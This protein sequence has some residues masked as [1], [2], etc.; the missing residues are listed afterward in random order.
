MI[1]IKQGIRQGAKLSTTMY[2][3]FN[4]NILYA[5]EDARIG[6]YI[7]SENVTSPTCAD[8]LALVHKETNALQTLTNIV[9]YHAC[10]DRFKINPTKSE[11]VHIYPQKKDS[12][13]EQE[14]KL[15]ESIIQQVE[16]SKH[17]GIERNSNNTP[18]IQER[19]RTARKTMYALMGAGMHGTDG[20]SPIITFNMWTTYVIPRMLHGIEMLTIRKGDINSLEMFQRKTFKQLQGLPKNAPTAAVYLLIGAIPA[21]G[22]IHLRF[23]STFGNI[24][25]NKDSLEYRVAKR[26]LV[27]KDGNSNSWFT[28]LV[29]IHEKYELPSPITLLENP[30]N[31][32]QWKTQYKTAVKKFWHDSLV[33]EANC[34]TSLNLLDTIGLKP[35]KPHTV[36][37]NVKNNPFEAHKAMVKVKLMTG[38][39]RFQCDRAKFSGGRISDTCKLCKKESED[40]HHFL[41]QCEVLDTKR[42]PYIQKLKSILSET[43]EEQVIEGII[44]DNE[45]MV[46]LTVDCTHPA[47]SRITHK[48][49]GKIE[50]TAR[51]MIYALHRER[52]AILVKE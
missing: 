34:K 9:H 5:L 8:D 12:I 16:E 43:H 45:K 26:Q 27:Y 29:Q 19:L 35:G 1:Q 13:E 30:P 39:Y 33:E 51:G 49:R 32:N 22:L 15:G 41:F 24:I 42:K 31:K 10:K 11:I 46:Q 7:G 28:T 52:S 47:V 48:N 2:K 21:E 36:W 50:Q 4:N 37:E 25:Q 17:L 23:L 6:T 20:L 14:V 40:M 38:T 44:Q 3:R 18:N